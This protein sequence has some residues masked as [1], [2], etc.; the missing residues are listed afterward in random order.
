M[1]AN[2]SAA[3]SRR[4]TLPP[5]RRGIVRM[6]PEWHPS[7]DP[8]PGVRFRIPF[9]VAGREDAPVLVVLG[10]ISANRHVCANAA[11]ASPGWWRS[12]VGPGLA[13]DPHDWCVVGIDFL[14]APGTLEPAGPED[15]VPRDRLHLT[16]EDQAAAIEVV[17]NR[18]GIDR[19]HRAVGASYGGMVALALG[20]RSPARVDG[21]VLIAAAHR[22]HPQATGVRSV[23]RGILE[24]GL[25]HGFES[26]SI[27]L[28]RALAFTTYKTAAGLD[29]RFAYGSGWSA[30]RPV[31]PID[32]FL[33]ERG[34][35]FAEHFDARAYLTLSASIDLCDLRPEETEVPCHAI[36]WA[37][38]ALVPLFLVEE[39][40]R[41]L[42]GPSDLRVLHSASGHDAFLL[43]APEYEAALRR[44]LGHPC[45]V[46]GAA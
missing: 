16:P 13:I 42:G 23:Q 26:D 34:R 46:G 4:P 31:H 15:A 32:R 19:V 22:P 44:G 20:I 17:L 27:A 35:A 18:L 2:A 41:R 21:L 29:A 24:A 39:M 30:G 33:R 6:P 38:D 25:R 5:G 12:L 7:L 43:D 37:E 28:A 14:G 11:D 1:N 9:E 8:E 40:H 45:V 10:G 3:I 36:A